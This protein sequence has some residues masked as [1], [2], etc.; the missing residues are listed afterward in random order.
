MMEKT[1]LEHIF[2]SAYHAQRSYRLQKY[3][4]CGNRR[5]FRLILSLRI[6]LHLIAPAQAL[7]EMMYK[8]KHFGSF[9]KTQ[10]RS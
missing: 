6:P 3:I 10:S 8:E 4:C 2:A 7:R 5:L 9:I 1:I